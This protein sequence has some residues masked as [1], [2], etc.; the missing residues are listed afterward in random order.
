MDYQS[1]IRK[2]PNEWKVKIDNHKHEYINIRYED[3]FQDK[4]LLELGGIS[5]EEWRKYNKILHELKEVKLKDFQ[6]KL[7]NQILASKSFLFRMYK[8]DNNLCSYCGHNPETLK[9]L[10]VDCQK[11]MHFGV[12]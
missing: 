2:I 7:N 5:I 3:N 1:V 10:F 12:H 6:F 8:I 11:E 4:W 9:H